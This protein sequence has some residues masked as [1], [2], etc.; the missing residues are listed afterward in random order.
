M[1]DVIVVGGGIIGSSIAY[2]LALRGM[3]VTVV[4]SPNRAPTSAAT[5]GWTNANAKQPFSYFALNVAGMGEHWA[6]EL[7]LD[8]SRF[9]HHIG[10]VEWASGA[11]EGKALLAKVE[12][13]RAWA[14]PA[15]IIDRNDLAAL[16]PALIVPDEAESI[17]FYPSEGYVDTMPL[18][19]RLLDRVGELR[20]EVRR[21]S[22][23]SLEAA[24]GKI[25]GITLEDGTQ[26]RSD[27]VVCA[28]GRWSAA[29]LATAGFRLPMA[30]TRGI[31]ATTT[32]S[33][34]PLRTMLLSSYIHL[35]PDGNG[36]VLLQNTS[37][38]SEGDSE[39]L[40]V[41]RA[42]LEEQLLDRARRVVRGLG[43]AALD[44][45][46]LGIRS[47]PGDHLTV[48]GWIPEC[49]GLYTV[50]THSGVTLGPLLARIAAREI[51]SGDVE[52]RLAE[53][54]PSRF[55]AT[56]SGAGR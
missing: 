6:L 7:E 29:L 37:I 17:V 38:D 24:A 46:E 32:P 16:D 2:R 14:Y 10:N 56:A 52:P 31:L 28:A 55:S 34:S 40:P 50:C 36:R 42:R 47:I 48:A 13:L 39:E 35:R 49:E 44:R 33:Q 21:D 9:F 54:R 15:E 25:H 51:A 41:P 1:I 23:K 5:F 4:G 45:V 30:P 27:Y 11:L 53:F 18:T 12:R 26:L 19:T 8:E 3:R 22:V 43:T 20:G